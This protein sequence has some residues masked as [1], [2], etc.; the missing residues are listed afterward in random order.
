MRSFSVHVV[1][2]SCAS[3][4]WTLFQNCSAPQFMV[5]QWSLRRQLGSG[6]HRRLQGGATWARLPDTDGHAYLTGNHASTLHFL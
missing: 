5:V 3:L 6:Q 4:T 1:N 2:R